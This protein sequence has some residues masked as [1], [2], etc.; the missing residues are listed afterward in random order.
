MSWPALRSGF[1]GR[2]VALGTGAAL[3]GAVSLFTGLEPDIVLPVR[4]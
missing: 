1:A 2:A 3:A 4:C